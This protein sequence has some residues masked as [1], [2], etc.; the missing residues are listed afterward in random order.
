MTP[1]EL[2]TAARNQYNAVG[3]TN[4]SSTEIYNLVYAACLELVR[5]CGF[6]IE[7]VYTTTT[8]AS[9]QDYAMPTQTLSVKRVTYDGKKLAPYTMRDDDSITLSN[10]ATTD[11]GEPDYYYQ[12]NDTLSLRPIP[13]EAKTL[14]VYTINYP[15]T[16]TSTSTLE[17]PEFTHMMIVDYIVSRMAAKDMNFDTASFHSGLWETH[18]QMLTRKLR[19]M[20]RGD[21]FAVVQ[22]EELHPITGLGNQ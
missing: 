19:Q 16:I 3:D 21:A 11:T 20:K 13:Q 15:Q 10:Q 22:A 1:G 4:W 7:R 12:W 18:K 8:V 2:E 14:K 9:T 17:V 6:I 5:D